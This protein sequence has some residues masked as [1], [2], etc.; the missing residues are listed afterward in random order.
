MDDRWSAERIGSYARGALRLMIKQDIPLTPENYTT[1]FK[2]ASGADS[3]LTKKIDTLLTNGVP[4]TPEANEELYHQFFIEKNDY[5]LRRIGGDLHLALVTLIKQVTELS[6]HTQ[7]YESFVSD[8]VNLLSECASLE[9]IRNITKEITNKTKTLAEFSKA[10]QD[11][12]KETTKSLE[13]LKKDFEQVKTEIFVDFLTGLANRKAFD[14]ALTTNM[15]GAMAESTDLS[16]LLIDIDR[17]KKFNDQYGH[18]VG[19][20]VLKYVAKRIKEIIRG[21]D[22]VARFGGEE[23]AVLLPRTSLA[24]AE[25]VAEN[26]RSFF[27]HASL[28]TASSSKRLGTL[29]VSIGVTSYR[30]GESSETFVSRCDQA[31]YSSKKA[32]RNQVTRA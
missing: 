12:L 8:S 29:T 30:Q 7:E 5:E 19:D 31:L 13:V 3:Q 11:E 14:E 23:F 20:E 4:F 10:L 22:L 24:G 27:A 28:K 9:D 21:G 2:Y 15:G 17:F 16:L 1:W 32:G 18:L 26:I 6:G 25:A